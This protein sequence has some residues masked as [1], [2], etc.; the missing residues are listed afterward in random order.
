MDGMRLTVEES[1]GNFFDA[2]LVQKRADRARIR[3]LSRLAA[4]IRTRAITLLLRHRVNKKFGAKS[5]IKHT[6]VGET[7]PAG[8]PPF[9]HTGNI[10]KFM[11]FGYDTGSESMVVGPALLGGVVNA[12]KELEEG[13]EATIARV[14]RAQGKR[15]RLVV[16]RR[17]TFTPHPFMAPA[18]AAEKVRSARLWANTIR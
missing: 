4:F 3:N 9:A 15:E 5:V 10:A 12:L 6:H 8:Q 1:K 2:M 14:I 11:F 18:L 7:A 16:T 13:G 17:V